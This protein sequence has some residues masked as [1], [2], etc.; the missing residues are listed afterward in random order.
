MWSAFL[1]GFAGSLHCVIMCGPLLILIGANQ[2]FSILSQLFYHISRILCYGLLGILVAIIGKGFQL[3]FGHQFLAVLMGTLLCLVGIQRLF[4]HSFFEFRLKGLDQISTSL[5]RLFF[6]PTI[7]HVGLRGFLNGFLPCGLVYVALSGAFLTHSPFE[8]FLFMLAFGMGT[9][10]ILFSLL[11]FKPFYEKFVQLQLAKI[12]PL[13]IILFGAL[14]I[15]R[16][17]GIDIPFLS[18]GTDY[19]QL[20]RGTARY[21]CS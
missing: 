12:I 10:P 17:L 8:G 4:A 11:F 16:G 5:T 2:N 7:A 13:I 9:T 20:S 3:S 14:L 15:I 18:P 6:K 21:N 1:L 19:L